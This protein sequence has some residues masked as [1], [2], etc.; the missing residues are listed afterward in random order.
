MVGNEEEFLSPGVFAEDALSREPV[1]SCT[2]HD[3]GDE[4]VVIDHDL[5]NHD[6]DLLWKVGKT[7]EFSFWSGIVEFGERLSRECHSL[8][9]FLS[10]Q[11]LSYQHL[12]L[13]LGEM[14]PTAEH[15]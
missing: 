11:A 9:L 14:T 3:L 8:A 2:L 7:D 12:F 10:S 6:L 13:L 15:S 1:L 5:P 4:V